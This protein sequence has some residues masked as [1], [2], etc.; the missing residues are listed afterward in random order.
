[1]GVAS[2]RHMTHTVAGATAPLTADG[3]PG[4]DGE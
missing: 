3:G 4:Q 2:E 1:M